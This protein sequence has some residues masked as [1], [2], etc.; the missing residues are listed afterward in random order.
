MKKYACLITLFFALWGLQTNCFGQDAGDKKKI[1]AIFGK[2][3]KAWNTHD[4]TYLS[5]PDITDENSVLINPVGMYWK[6]R[7]EIAKGI[8]YLSEVRF[9]FMDIVERT[10]L[11]LRFLSPSVALV[12]CSVTDEV[13]QDFTMPGETTVTKKGERMKAT[14]SYTFVKQNDSWKISSLQITEAFAGK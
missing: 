14:Q 7:D 10:I 11:T 13:R 9:K 2:I 3:D 1:D 8:G 6:N 5:S 4:F 12:V